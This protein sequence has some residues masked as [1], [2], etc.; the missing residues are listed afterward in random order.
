LF[1]VIEEG[2]GFVENEDAE[3]GEIHSARLVAIVQVV[4]DLSEGRDDH[5]SL[6]IKLILCQIAYFVGGCMLHYFLEDIGNL[7]NELTCV[8]NHD[9]L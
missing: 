6:G 4:V 8:S 9:Y 3:L 5:L 1:I 2:V 7:D